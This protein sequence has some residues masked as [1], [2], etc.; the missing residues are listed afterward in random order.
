MLFVSIHTVHVL[1]TA[2]YL[3]LSNPIGRGTI[4]IPVKFFPKCLLGQVLN[5]QHQDLHGTS[6]KTP[7]SQFS[8]TVLS[9]CTKM[10][11][12]TLSFKYQRPP[13]KCRTPCQ[14]VYLD[15][16]KILRYF[17]ACKFALSARRRVQIITRVTR[18]WA[19]NCRSKQFPQYWIGF[20]SCFSTRDSSEESLVVRSAL[21]CDKKNA[22]L[23]WNYAN[24]GKP[25]YE[26]PP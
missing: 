13:M 9:K 23:D 5:F 17:W 14:F 8:A 2:D 19:S 7:N 18:N 15:K 4:A 1:N 10:E 24:F 25:Q 11:G 12:R 21:S 6:I 26:S 16:I 3:K 22:I 20:Q